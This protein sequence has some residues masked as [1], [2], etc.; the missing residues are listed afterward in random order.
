MG[1]SL[2]WLHQLRHPRHCYAVCAI[3]RSGSNLLT[4]GLHATQHAGRPKQFFLHTFEARYGAKHGLDPEIN[5]AAYVSGIVNKEV[6][7][8]GVFGFKL[9]SW[10]LERF[11]GRLRATK[12][13]GMATTPDVQLLQN[14]FPHLRFIRIVRR[15]KLRQAISKARAAQTGVW[16]ITAGKTN[17]RDAQFNRELI[18]QCL[19]DGEHQEAIWN[20]FFERAAVDAYAV[21]YEELCE[22]YEVTLRRVLDFLRIPVPPHVTI[23]SPRTIRQ[24][25]AVSD[26]W[27]RRFQASAVTATEPERVLSHV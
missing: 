9:M 26:D 18:V 15:N 5:Y 6:S 3:P 25:D 24:A 4:D 11:L 10:Y 16:K 2:D 22:D 12:E 8:N 7:S 20:R 13:F 27:E 14:A 1:A 21:H 19:R 23:G 17:G